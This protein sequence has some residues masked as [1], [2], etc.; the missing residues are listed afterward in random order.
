MRVVLAGASGLIGSALLRRLAAAGHDVAQL[1]RHAPHTANE[2]QWDPARG[3]VDPAALAGADVVICLSG[4]GVGDHRWTDDYKRVLT[5]SRMQTVGTLA[6]ALADGSGPRT[7]LAASAVGY[8]GDRGDVVLD[9]TAPAGAGFLA[10]LCEQWEAAA[11][12]ARASGIRVAHLRTGLV[13]TAD[14]GLLKRLK[15]LFQTGLAGKLG[16]GSQFMPW[17]SLTDELRAIEY[18]ITAELSG[19]V[20]LTAPEPARNVDFTKALGRV[21]HRPTVLPA[22]GFALKVALGE[23]GGEALASQRVVPAALLADGF[24]FTHTN[25]DEA[26]RDALGR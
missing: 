22:P 24:T 6:R 7:L 17:I 21:L 10:S 12:P 25:L 23:F 13:L 2:V 14:G 15:L 3:Q 5:E 16:S 1:V 26:L 20:N 18:L 4:A 9:E 19:P 8:Y 11:E